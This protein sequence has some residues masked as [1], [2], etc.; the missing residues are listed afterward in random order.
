MYN[1]ADKEAVEHPPIVVVVKWNVLYSV[2]VPE[3]VNTPALNWATI[4]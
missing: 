4:P 3:M 2:G 1:V